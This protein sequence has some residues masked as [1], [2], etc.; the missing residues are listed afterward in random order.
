MV[1]AESELI[2]M[3]CRLPEFHVTVLCG[4]CCVSVQRLVLD[5]NRSNAAMALACNS[6][7]CT[8]RFQQ[9]LAFY[10]CRLLQLQWW[11]TANSLRCSGSGFW[12][13]C[14]ALAP[15]WH[16]T[17]ASA[18]HPKTRTPSAADILG[19]AG[20][21]TLRSR[22]HMAALPAD[23][24]VCAMPACE[25]A[26]MGQGRM[27]VFWV[28]CCLVVPQPRDGLHEALVCAALQAVL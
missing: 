24:L 13:A 28:Q 26:I 15:S 23:S 20:P 14:Y 4:C 3:P 21:Y 12:G 19:C 16:V 5:D 1:S 7:V 10:E 17:S 6:R 11:R 18:A 25:R 27:R 2:A 22:Q 8:Y 9:P